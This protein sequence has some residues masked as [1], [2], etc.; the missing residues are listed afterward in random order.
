MQKYRKLLNEPCNQPLSHQTRYYIENPRAKFQGW[1]VFFLGDPN[2]V[3]IQRRAEE[4]ADYVANID[5][6]IDSSGRKLLNWFR[7]SLHEY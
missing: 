6:E 5:G 3:A 2:D 7:V 4:V 1:I